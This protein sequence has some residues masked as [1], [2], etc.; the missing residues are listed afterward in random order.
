[1]AVVRVM[2]VILDQ[3]INVIAMWNRL[4]SAVRAMNV[5]LV[6]RSTVMVG[7]AVRRIGA[8]HLNPVLVDMV[9][10]N[11]VQVAVV[12]IVDMA[13][14]LHRRMT[15]GRTMSVTVT[16]MCRVRLIHWISP[17]LTDCRH[18][19]RWQRSDSSGGFPGV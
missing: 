4:V 19:V 14:V 8:A 6:V 5:I 10:L 11:T 18:L 13:I 9:A 7:S 16:F 1:M 2:Q 12:K 17:F 15:A 3:V